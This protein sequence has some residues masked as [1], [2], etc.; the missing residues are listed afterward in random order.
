MTKLLPNENK[1][2]QQLFQLV[3]IEV[4][5][6]YVQLVKRTCE[7]N[8]QI[9]P[10]YQ[11]DQRVFTFACLQDQ[12]QNERVQLGIGQF[13]IVNRQDLAKDEA[14]LKQAIVERCTTT[15][16]QHSQY[17]FAFVFELIKLEKV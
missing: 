11:V 7:P 2:S 6:F 13:R 14:L 10:L 16:R 8:K 15:G 12:V 9:M 17:P 4:L 1:Y 5:I 3:R